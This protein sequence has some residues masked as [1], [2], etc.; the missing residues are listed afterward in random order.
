MSTT[1]ESPTVLQLSGFTMYTRA[2]YFA[3]FGKPAPPCDPARASKQWI[4]NGTFWFLESLTA[5]IVF[6]QETIPPSDHLPNLPGVGPY[7]AYVL[8]PTATFQP[9]PGGSPT[10]I[11]L[12]P[13]FLSLQA[14]AQALMDQLGATGLTD[15]GTAAPRLLSYDP[16]DQRRKWDFTTAKGVYIN[17]GALLFMRNAQG[18]GA[19]GHWDQSGPTPTWVADSP[20]PNPALPTLGPPCRALAANES[21]QATGIFGFA[22]LIVDD[23]QPAPA[24]PSPGG[25]FTVADRQQL[26]AV[27]ESVQTILS[28]VEQLAQKT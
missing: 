25:S 24:P 1:S 17:A 22:T 21:L 7:P 23:G 2:S 12:N 19:P 28:L 5:P 11:P 4:G 15:D 8:A 14:D 13:L 20:A 9:N 16:T 6:K 27:A 3:Q 10:E 18:V 26:N